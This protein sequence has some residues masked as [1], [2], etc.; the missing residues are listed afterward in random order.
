MALKAAALM[1][2]A[3]SAAV[4]LPRTVYLPLEALPA[5]PQ[6]LV[7]LEVGRSR[8]TARRPKT[9]L[10]GAFAMTQ[11]IPCPSC[12]RHVRQSESECPFC[13]AE[14]SLAH[15]PAPLLPRSRLGRAATFAFGATVVGATALV[16][17]GSDDDDDGGGKG[18]KGGTTAMAGMSNGGSTVGPVYGAPAGGTGGDTASGGSAG[19]GN[20][21][22]G[23]MALYGAPPSGGTG[24]TGNVPVY[25]AAPAD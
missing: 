16:G 21:G 13:S 18:G 17:C 19:T 14:L 23:G 12:N 11:L 3:A 2:V 9:E 1:A 7:H 25:G 20:T 10:R 22:G 6:M 15:V 5:V 4:S 8:R 24:G